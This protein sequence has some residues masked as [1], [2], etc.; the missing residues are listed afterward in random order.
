VELNRLQTL[1][2]IECIDDE[3]IKKTKLKPVRDRVETFERPAW[4]AWVYGGDK[5]A[6]ER[7]WEERQAPNPALPEQVMVEDRNPQES[8]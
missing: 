4:H 1:T 2:E 8:Q 5:G 6:R 7:D 3:P